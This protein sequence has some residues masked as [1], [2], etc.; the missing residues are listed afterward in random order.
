MRNGGPESLMRTIRDAMIVYYEAYKR[1]ELGFIHGG[2]LFF[3]PFF[4]PFFSECF[5][6][7]VLT[8]SLNRY[9]H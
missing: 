2:K 6:F 5:M 3:F 7:W 4:F 1:P 9:F 8:N